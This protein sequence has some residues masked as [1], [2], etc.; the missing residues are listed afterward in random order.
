VVS[1]RIK[2][3]YDKPEEND[4]Y[5][6][7]V[8][9][10]WPRGVKKEDLKLDSWFKEIAPSNEFRKWFGHENDKWHEFRERYFKEL[11]EKEDSIRDLVEQARRGRI[12]LVFGAKNRKE[13]NAVA[14]KEYLANMASSDD[15]DS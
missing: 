1:I 14:L 9:R 11:S 6:V 15:S 3:A 5:R 13:N 12:T 2:R 8:D 7:L 10:M 4:G